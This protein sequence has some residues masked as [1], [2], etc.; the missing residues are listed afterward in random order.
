[1]NIEKIGL[2]G[3]TGF[4][5]VGISSGQKIEELDPL[6]VLARRIE[7]S[8]DENAS[9]VGIITGDELARMQRH[10][11]LESLDLI[12]GTQVLSTAGLMGNTGS[13]IIRGLPSRYQQIMVDGVRVS[14]SSNSLGNFLG[15]GQLGQI[16]SIE[17]LRGPQSVLYGTGAGGGVIG[18]ETSVG[19]G[20][21]K[22]QLFGEGGSFETFRAAW[23]SLGQL[24][25]FSYG[26]EVGSQFSGNDTYEALSLHDYDQTYMNLALEWQLDDDLRLK[27]SYRGTDNFLR[28]RASNI[29]GV[30]NSEIETET[31]L[32]AANLSYHPNPVWKSLLTTGVYY[33]NYRGDFDASLYGTE[34]ERWTINWSNEF[35]FGEA[36]TV[37]GGLESSIS[38]FENSSDRS[39]DERILGA[40]VN[41]YYRPVEPLLLEAGGR[42]DENIEFDGDFAWNVGATYTLSESGTRFHA[43]ASEAYRNPSLLDSEF[44]PSIFSNQLANPDLQ[45][46]QILGWETGVTQ[47][48][49]DHEISATYYQQALEDAIVTSFPAA[50]TSQRVNQA[51]MSSVS[52]LEISASGKLGSNPLSYRMAFTSQFDEEVID[53]P[54]QLVSFDLSYNKDNWLIGGGISYADEAAYLVPGNQKTDSRT[55]SRIY[56]RYQM[57]DFVSLHIRIENVF[58]QDYQLFPDTFGERTGIEGPG[59]A[60][61]AGA[62]LSW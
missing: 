61:Y 55:L 15:N 39:V 41:F 40:Y 46:E 22:H 25:N 31:G 3:L 57:T 44:F 58:D 51:G 4:F 34:Q 21:P 52:G 8:S 35:V 49:G 36:I 48:L 43:R 24:E 54:N 2:I 27:V 11:L 6:T 60:V 62:T 14:D 42:Y 29:F 53:H 45:S 17:V 9:S 47:Q 38:S 20:D 26:I 19:F 16:T 18:Y 7:S 5:G 33:E 32:L 10:R 59:R 1:M 50:G 30:S 12:P 56:G 13:A 28:T 37:V 23:S